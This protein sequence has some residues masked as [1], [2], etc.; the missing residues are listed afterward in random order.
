MSVSSERL[1]ELNTG[2]D[3]NDSGADLLNH[4]PAD[5]TCQAHWRGPCSCSRPQTGRV[6]VTT[7]GNEATALQETDLHLHYVYN[8]WTSMVGKLHL[9]SPLGTVALRMD[10][11]L[12]MSFLFVKS[13]GLI[14]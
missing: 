13:E 14:S 4:T 10:S 1:H 7:C 8:D 3:C 6:K 9:L 5:L 11:P 2:F 12:Q